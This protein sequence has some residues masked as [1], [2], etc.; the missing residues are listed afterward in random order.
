MNRSPEEYGAYWRASL[1][2]T[3]G[4]LLAVGGYHFVGPLFRDPGLGT[5]LF[6]WLL[7]GLFL[8]VGCYFAV[9]GLARTIEVAGGR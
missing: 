1:F 3:A 6:G 5:T 9:L 2:I 7:F 4:A 8:T